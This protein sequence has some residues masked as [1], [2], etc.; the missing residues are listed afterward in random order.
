MH[1]KLSYL[2]AALRTLQLK[3]NETGLLCLC[4]NA[5]GQLRY[6]CHMMQ[7]SMLAV[8]TVQ[9][10]SG[11]EHALPSRYT[12]VQASDRSCYSSSSFTV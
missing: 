10:S 7:L 5:T 4:T 1:I 8:L 6:L 11:Q 3:L 12:E 2:Y 9:V